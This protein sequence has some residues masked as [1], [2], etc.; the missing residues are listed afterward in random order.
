ML[1]AAASRLSRRLR[2]AAV[3]AL[4]RWLHGTDSCELLD[5]TMTVRHLAKARRHASSASLV[6]CCA[7][8]VRPKDVFVNQ[9]L[10]L[11]SLEWVGFDFECASNCP[12]FEFP[13]AL[14]RRALLCSYTLAQYKT[15]VLGATIYELAKAHLVSAR[16]Y[17]ESLSALKYD[18]NFAVR[19]VAYDTKRGYLLKLDFLHSVSVG[20]AF[21][22]RRQLTA[23]E[24]VAAYGSMVVTGAELAAFRP[25]V[26]L[27]CLPE[28]A[29][30]CFCSVF[31]HLTFQ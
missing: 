10:D 30:C 12:S 20:N 26:D 5:G 18:P 13:S 9:E 15:D 22:G 23:D 11:A 16:Q 2:S 25:M 28:G 14:T 24:I 19:G 3:P 6:S 7:V 21:F 31:I 29:R 27:F 1:A 8:Q 17:P 4:R